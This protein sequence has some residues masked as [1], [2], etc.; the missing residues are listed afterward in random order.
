MGKRSSM[1]KVPKDYYPTSDPKA[2]PPA[3]IKEVRGKPYAEPCCGEGHLVD[4]LA[5]VATCKWESD[6][7]WRGAGREKDAMGVTKENLSGCDLILTNPPY[8]RSVLLPMIDHFISLKPTWLLLPSDFM[9]N[10]Y[11]GP[12]MAKCSKVIS[13]GRLCWFPKDGKRVAST[14]NYSWYYWKQ[15]ANEDTETVFIGR[16]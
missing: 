6:L 9:H 1:E 2:L 13:I 5:D 4:L 10:L 14:D 3:F 16:T 11:F 15:L 8:T 7:E 12:Y